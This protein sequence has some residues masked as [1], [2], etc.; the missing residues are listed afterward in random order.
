MA[1]SFFGNNPSRRGA[2][3]PYEGLDAKKRR[4]LENAG[5]S[6]SN[7]AGT[8]GQHL[9]E[10][11]PTYNANDC[12]IILG[13]NPS[14]TNTQIIL[15]R[16]RSG[17]K[18]SG[19]GGIG[20]TQAGAI[21]IVVG[22]GGTEPNDG[23]MINAQFI[24]GDA[25]RIY[26][27][28]KCDIDKYFGLCTGLKV[29][30]PKAVSG[31]GIKADGVR[32]VGTNGIKLVTGGRDEKN[33]K[34]LDVDVIQGIELIA[35]NTSEDASQPLVKGDNLLQCLRSMQGNIDELNGMIDKIT[36]TL[37]SQSLALA[38]HVHVSPGFGAPTTPGTHMGNSIN[39]SIQ[40][41]LTEL[42]AWM[43]KINQFM[44]ENEYLEPYGPKYI[45]SKY[46]TTN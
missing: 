22:R 14:P 41:T 3:S 36:R 31:I 33:S 43:G 7:N 26:I 19:Y 4:L 8:G 34:G 40:S 5:A 21:D 45:L 23:D 17:A 28:Q 9:I 32:I 46:N 29:M 20:A 37:R 1:I 27:S 13:E 30:N 44:A 35:G 15:G 12:D 39:A 25:A 16:D 2:D 11:V 38:G 24:N 18:M 42:G 10:P 6:E